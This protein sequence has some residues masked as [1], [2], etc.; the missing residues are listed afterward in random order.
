MKPEAQKELLIW[1]GATFGG[2]VLGYL[3]VIAPMVEKVDDKEAIVASDYQQ[4]RQFYLDDGGGPRA[5]A[6]E[7]IDA[8]RVVRDAQGA[9]LT[10]MEFGWCYG[11]ELSA[12]ALTPDLAE[13]L[14]AAYAPLYERDLAGTQEIAVASPRQ[15]ALLLIDRLREDRARTIAEEF[16]AEDGTLFDFHQPV[17]YNEARGYVR[18]VHVR[19][20]VR[21]TTSQRAAGVP[22][23][24]PATEE[25]P[26][27][28]E[29]DIDSDS[30]LIRGLQLAEVCCFA[31]TCDLVLDVFE[32]GDEHKQVHAV[33]VGGPNRR[34]RTPD[35]AYAMVQT[36][37]TLTCIY[38]TAKEI[39][40][41]LDRSRS[42]LFLWDLRLRK[43]EGAA[44]ELDMTVGLLLRNH[45]DW[46]LEAL[47]AAR[48]PRGRA[49]ASTYGS[50]R[51]AR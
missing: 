11:T 6:E 25:L 23:P 36:S 35:E 27:R 43:L 21:A 38:D 30:A 2:L 1:G 5:E 7:A 10:A 12:A 48:A 49:G 14:I 17:S 26:Y 51:R 33:S 47:T 8:L 9:A 34:Y 24:F 32:L 31:T 29:R 20:G 22:V 46:G 44:Y 50:R 28:G 4:Y 16:V 15:Q 41:R 42:G 18:E 37:V 39:L 19:L 3:L 13:E 40:Q 45:P